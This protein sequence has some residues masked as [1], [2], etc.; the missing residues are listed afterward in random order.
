MA[1]LCRAPAGA[2]PRAADDAKNVRIF[3]LAELPALAFDHATILDD[4]RR[5]KATGQRPGPSR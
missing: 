2:K 4:Y 3:P 5:Y 1:F